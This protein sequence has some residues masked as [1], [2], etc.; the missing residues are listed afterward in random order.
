MSRRSRAGQDPCG[1][2]QQIEAPPLAQRVDPAAAEFPEFQ[3][4]HRAPG[5]AR[6]LGAPVPAAAVVGA[7]V[8]AG[9]RHARG[10]NLDAA[11]LVHLAGGDDDRIVPQ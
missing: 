8:L 2:H 5:G 6:A 11:A 9:P 7:R 3:L 10:Q 4:E 1:A